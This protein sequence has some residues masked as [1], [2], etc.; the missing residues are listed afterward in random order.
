MSKAFHVLKAIGFNITK[1]DF[2]SA[3]H[4]KVG[5]VVSS[6][7]IRQAARLVRAFGGSRL[8]STD[9]NK[10]AF[11]V[12][13]FEVALQSHDENP[14]HTVVS[15]TTIRVNEIPDARRAVRYAKLLTGLRSRVVEER[16]GNV[17]VQV[18][19]DKAFPDVLKAMTSRVGQPAFNNGAMSLWHDG[20]Q[21][22]ALSLENGHDGIVLRM[23]TAIRA[24]ARV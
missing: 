12:G 8:K 16:A 22:Y 13:D 14:K 5:W 17:A 20:K 2:N 24:L 23:S 19:T 1:S 4:G 6:L 18:R 3:N 9:A 21:R 11:L 7:N 10:R 15:I